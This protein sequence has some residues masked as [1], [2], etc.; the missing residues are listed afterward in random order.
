[1]TQKNSY[2]VL[3]HGFW[4]TSKSL[5][6]I[7]RVLKRKGY[8][9]V[10]VNYPSK[11]KTIEECAEYLKRVIEEKCVDNNKTINF[12]T[13]SM[14][15]IVLRYYLANNNLINLGRVVMSAPPNKASKWA[16][17]LC[18]FKIARNLLGPALGQF[19]S[20]GESILKKLPEPNYEVGIIAGKYDFTVP[21]DD[22][23]LK[24]MKDYMLVP[25]IH[26]FILD[27][28]LAID[29]AINF[30]EMGSFRK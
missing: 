12:I 8:V 10:N 28:D 30:L 15:G 19:T 2:V 6:K 9:V 20:Y 1:M 25:K 18:K 24:N 29:G 23:K 3:L 26:T 5:S 4:R 7:E 21:G 16:D 17:L 27:D 13:H 22:V 11:S 14:G